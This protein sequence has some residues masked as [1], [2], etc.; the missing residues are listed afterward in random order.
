MK[1]T[2]EII[3]L[4]KKLN[5]LGYKKE[6]KYGDWYTFDNGKVQIHIY[7]ELP[8]ELFGEE[9]SKDFIPIP[10]ISD[11]LAWLTKNT[12]RFDIEFESGFCP[13]ITIIPLPQTNESLEKIDDIKNPHEVV[14]K[15]MVKVLEK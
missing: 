11:G 4:A 2:K 1:P 10:S 6:I 12:T 7:N 14:L 3:E 8:S 15:A 5:D 13:T 9:R